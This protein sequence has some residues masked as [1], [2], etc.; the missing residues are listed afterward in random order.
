MSGFDSNLVRKALQGAGQ[1]GDHPDADVL[2][3]FAEGTLL[4]RERESV[5]THAAECAECRR[6]LN[7][8][9]GAALASS[10]PEVKSAAGRKWNVRRMWIPSVAAAA[11]VALVA[12][13]VMRNQHEKQE[14]RQNV[15]ANVPATVSPATPPVSANAQ[16]E[17]TPAKNTATQRAKKQDV[18]Q[19]QRSPSSA[20]DVAENNGAMET[21]E[22]APTEASRVQSPAPVSAF[23]NSMTAKALASAPASS[24]ARPHWRLN[25]LGQPERTFGNGVWEQV[26][27]TKSPKMHVLSIYAGEVWVGGDKSTVMR[28]FDNGTTWRVVPLPEKNGKDHAIAHIRFENAETITIEAADGAEW[29]SVDGGETWK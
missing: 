15:A 12:I 19:S 2:A 23:S 3:A 20:S 4:T 18:P 5:L 17:T 7:L 1:S 26:L 16:I 22:I 6:V 25:D 10:L 8:A 14:A 29:S 24:I 27:P 21:A 13:L 9:A 28:S 11:A